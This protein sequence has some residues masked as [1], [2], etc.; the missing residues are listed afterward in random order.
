LAEKSPGKIAEK[1]PAYGR[2]PHPHP[3]CRQLWT[4]RSMPV[5]G[6]GLS[7]PG[8]SWPSLLGHR[9]PGVP[10]Q[11][12][13]AGRAGI[14]GC[15]A[16]S[17]R[18]DSAGRLSR[19]GRD[20]GDRVIVPTSGRQVDSC[21][22]G[23]GRQAGRQPRGRQGTAVGC[24]VGQVGQVP[25]RLG[26]GRCRRRAGC[27][28]AGRDSASADVGQAGR[29]VSESTGTRQ[30]GHVPTSAGIRVIVGRSGRQ[31]VRG[32]ASTRVGRD[33]GRD[34]IGIGR[35]PTSG[36]E[37]DERAAPRRGPFVLSPSVNRTGDNGRYVPPR[38]R[39]P[40]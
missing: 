28:E 39:Q 35:D 4:A 10:V 13:R 26:I 7:I 33:S 8:Q 40:T 3:T 9:P 37:H 24:R 25:R 21:R 30:V 36:R 17:R 2:F 19:V 20:P 15:R 34:G 38:R 16:A 31:A 11:A 12:G 22:Q 32:R 5:E 23:L 1:S 14:R 6:T 18:R 27:P 29:P